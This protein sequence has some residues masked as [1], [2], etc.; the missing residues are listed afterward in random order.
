MQFKDSL[1]L[2]SIYIEYNNI[3]IEYDNIYIDFIYCIFLLIFDYSLN[4]M[5]NH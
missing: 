1:I 2:I 4:I 3:D 5:F